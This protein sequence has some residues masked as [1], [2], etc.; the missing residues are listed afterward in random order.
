MNLPVAGLMELCEPSDD[1][2]TSCFLAFLGFLEKLIVQSAKCNM[3]LP[4]ETAYSKGHMT[5]LSVK[6]NAIQSQ[7]CMN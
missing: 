2:S 7:L 5:Q 6:A 3:Q 4:Q 1:D